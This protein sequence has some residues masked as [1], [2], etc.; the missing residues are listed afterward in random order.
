MVKSTELVVGCEAVAAGLAL[1]AFYMCGQGAKL[2]VEVLF[3]GHILYYL[4]TFSFA[5]PGANHIRKFVCVFALAFGDMILTA[6][7]MHQALPASFSV[8]CLQFICVFT[9][10]HLLEP[11]E[12]Q[13]QLGT[14][15]YRGALFSLEGVLKS[16]MLVST[17]KD[18]IVSYH[19]IKPETVFVATILG[20]LRILLAPC[21]YSA[22]QYFCTAQRKVVV[23]D[24]MM[25]RYLRLSPLLALVS[26]CLLARSLPANLADMQEIGYT[27]A[28]L[29]MNAVFLAWFAWDAIGYGQR[30][31]AD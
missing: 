6:L 25:L 12:V 1:L 22:D 7:L 18:V 4:L 10:V 23:N 17:V 9:V 15:Y 20:S 11:Q 16:Y 29:L 28:H 14:N 30:Q 8:L 27:P 26:L 13:K 31:A 19:G 2:P 21:V 5:C 3:P 24:D